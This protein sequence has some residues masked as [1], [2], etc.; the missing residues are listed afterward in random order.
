M[1]LKANTIES[2]V[3]NMT[4]MIDVV[5]LLLIF[6]MVAAKFTNLERRIDLKVPRVAQAAALTPAPA[7]R[8]V[9][10]YA[11]GRI[12]LDGEDVSLD[13]LTTRLF[14]LQAQFDD[15]PVL[16][17]G[18]ANAAHQRVTEVLAACRAAGLSQPSLA[19]RPLDGE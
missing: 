17:R 14:A 8:V 18:E 13:E 15:A 9:N 3:V 5:F 6:F 1:P 2:P 12:M 7:R 11:D 10:I 16:I 19:V 4:P